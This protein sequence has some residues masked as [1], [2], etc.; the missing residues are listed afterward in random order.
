[1][2]RDMNGDGNIDDHDLTVI[3]RGQ[4]IHI[5]GLSNNFAYRGLSLNVFFQWSYGNNIYNANRLAM[6]GGTFANM[7]QFASYVNRWSPENQTNENHRTRGGG[8]FG[9]YSSK[10]VE[11]GSYLRLKTLSLDYSLPS[12]W[13][14]RAYLKDLTL[15]LAAQ[16]L[17]TWTNYSGL[18]P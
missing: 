17:V 7:N 18:D 8:P 4:P 16:N 13:I 2:Y 12:R 6:E 10:V 5:G 1:R 15:S 11:D 9:F 3:G 14:R